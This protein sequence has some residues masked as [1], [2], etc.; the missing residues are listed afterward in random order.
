MYIFN[1]VRLVQPRA[2]HLHP[3]FPWDTQTRFGF[4]KFPHKNTKF[5]NFFPSDRVGSKAGRPLFYCS[6]LCSD[7]GQSL[8]N[9]FLIQC[10]G[11]YK[12]FTNKLF[13]NPVFAVHVSFNDLFPTNKVPNT[14][15]PELS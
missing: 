10:G 2:L 12:F 6:K 15:F 7:Q 14:V 4:G 9:T 8:I 3:P 5:F 1:T 13:P 11:Y